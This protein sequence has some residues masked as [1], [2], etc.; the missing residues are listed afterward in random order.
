MN[1]Y[2]CISSGRYLLLLLALSTGLCFAGPIN[3]SQLMPGNSL[4]LLD[5]EA[6][7]INPASFLF[8][9]NTMY[10]FNGEYDLS[11]VSAV[12]DPAD[13][14]SLD[15]VPLQ[16]TN[17]VL[18]SSN[19]ATDTLSPIAS[20]SDVAPVPEPASLLLATWAFG[21]LL[22]WVAGKFAQRVVKPDEVVN[23]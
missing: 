23:R 16:I 12:V 19:D 9:E 11:I 18:G 2:K 4:D 1:I 15:G 20:S 5:L 13:T 14:S 8:T 21:C 6:L 7:G 3:S 17:I 22:C 10:D